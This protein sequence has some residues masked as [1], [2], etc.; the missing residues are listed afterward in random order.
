MG[1]PAA[2]PA[3]ARMADFLAVRVYVG[4]DHA[5]FELK[6]HL[7]SHLTAQGHEVSDIGPRVYD[8]ADD[9][10][11]FCIGPA[12]RVV[13]GRG[14]LGSSTRSGAPG[15]HSPGSRRS[16][17]LPASTTTPRWSRSAR[18]CIPPQRLPR[19]SRCSSRRSLRLMSVT[20]AASTSFSSTSAPARPRRCP[21]DRPMERPKPARAWLITPLVAVVV[22]ILGA[23]VLLT[24]QADPTIWL[25]ACDR[26]TFIGCGLA[27]MFFCAA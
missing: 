20:N 27:A 22:T 12:R 11:A 21:S 8:A 6:N 15:R 26:R 25:A 10:P 2:C 4:S 13:A 19:S 1:T 9:Y 16:P 3:T 14:R 5:G 18:G 17:S 23:I 7:V 24:V